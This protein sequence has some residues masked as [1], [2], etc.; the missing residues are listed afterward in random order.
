M[1]TGHVMRCLALAQAWQ[2]MDGEATLLSRDLPPALAERASAEGIRPLPLPDESDDLRETSKAAAEANWVVIDGYHF[3]ASFSEGVNRTARHVLLI[4]DLAQ[5]PRYPAELILN[6]NI[7]ASEVMYAG[8]DSGTGL[9]MGCRHALLRREFRRPLPERDALAGCERVLVTL[10]GSDPDNVTLKVIDALMLLP[11]LHARVIV[12]SANPHRE[13]LLQ[14]CNAAS[15]R[16]EVFPMVQDLVPMMDWAQLAVSA[17]GTSVL[18]LASRGVPA[19][20]IAIAGNQRAICE[21]MHRDKV[22]VCAGWHEDLNADAL[23]SVIGELAADLSAPRRADFAARG[24]QLVDGRGAARVARE[25]MARDAMTAV[26]IRPAAMEDARRVMEWANDPVTRS[27]SFHQ[28]QITW[29]EHRAWFASRLDDSSCRLMIGEDAAGTA[30]GMLRFDVEHEDATIS[31]NIAPEHR[32]RGLGT[33]LI[34]VACRELLDTGGARRIRA[35]IKPGNSESLR[36]FRRAGFESAPGVDV[37]GQG[38][39]C[40]VLD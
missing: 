23:A 7:T 8:C 10:G 5:L 3:D 18:E 27:V 30:I 1:G 6:Q 29:E 28:G 21:T 11:R 37:A 34:L 35:L 12:G 40:M 16:I 9:L 33:A 25:M 39:L 38:A 20:L 36:A 26:R 31:I 2:D 15:G 4:D 13:S 19:V 17:G 32:R 22:M 24:P 14:R